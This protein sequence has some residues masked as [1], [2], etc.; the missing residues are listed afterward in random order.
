MKFT[1]FRFARTA[2]ALAAP[3]RGYLPIIAVLV[4]ANSVFGSLS[5]IAVLPLLEAVSAGAIGAS[6]M[7]G[8]DLSG[9]SDVTRYTLDLFDWLGVENVLTGL[10]VLLIGLFFLK[11]LVQFLSVVASYAVAQAIRRVW[12]M[13]LA[14][15]YMF[16][17]YRDVSGINLGKIVNNLRREPKLAAGFMQAYVQQIILYCMA[18]SL[19]AAVLFIDWLLV[20]GCITVLGS[21]YL[22]VGRPLF[23]ISGRLGKRNVA[24]SQKNQGIVQETSR[25]IKELR[26]GNYEAYQARKLLDSIVALNKNQLWFRSVQ[27]IP[28]TFGRFI[29]VLLGGLVLVWVNE[30]Y[31]EDMSA[32]I[33]QFV[34]VM[35]AVSRIFDLFMQIATKN[36][37]LANKFPSSK[38]VLALDRAISRDAEKDVR[39]SG[40]DKPVERLR[41][42]IALQGVSFSHVQSEIVLHDLNLSLDPGRTQY[43]VG[44]SGSGKSTIIDLLVR[45]YEPQGGR[46]LCNGEAIGS[47]DL[48]AWR[49]RIGY[50][51]QSSVLFAQ[52]IRENITLGSAASQDWLDQVVAAAG[53]E[54]VVAAFPEGLDTVLDGA[55]F[56]LSEGQRKRIAI[57][58]ALFRKPD[59]IIVDE[60]MTAIEEKL[61]HKILA[62]IR[63]LLPEAT[64]IVV[65]HRISTIA[66]KERVILLDAGRVAA[67]GTLAEIGDEVRLRLTEPGGAIDAAAQ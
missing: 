51:G 27:N 60:A 9:L 62:N 6:G 61:E 43:L 13:R 17:P 23:R 30:Y 40:G 66:P 5:L 37:E 15:Y 25:S 4:I 16:A 49:G 36:V 67:D 18:I 31:T 35:I 3:V 65:T 33:A 28:T 38:L 44:R 54:D 10:A 24:L 21:L 45:L 29:P 42:G 50:S 58:R 47:F 57:A 48:A 53:L 63:G 7:D 19:L 20:T 32:F 2:L 1:D 14:E 64:V 34:F 46:I 11:A 59:L 22:L 56:G 41:S 12:M 52:S 26:I 39:R 8:L 55:G